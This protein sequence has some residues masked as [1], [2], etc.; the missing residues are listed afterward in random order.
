MSSLERK[1]KRK[2]DKEAKKLENKLAKK[3]NMF[4][5]L[6]N[7]C[8]MCST[9]YDK[10]NKEQATTWRVIIKEEK[11]QLFCPKCWIKTFKEKK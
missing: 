2:Q 10:K 11:I 4:D 3:L 9:D 1:L 8:L 7:N 6:P 5:K